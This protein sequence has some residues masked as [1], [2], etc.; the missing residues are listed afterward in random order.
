MNPLSKLMQERL[1]KWRKNRL[2]VPSAEKL[3]KGELKPFSEPYPNTYVQRRD[4]GDDIRDYERKDQE[5]WQR[6]CDANPWLR[7]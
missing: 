7:R 6:Q 2:T 3:K 5:A 1:E 4:Y